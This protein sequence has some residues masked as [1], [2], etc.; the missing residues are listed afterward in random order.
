MLLDV[1]ANTSERYWPVVASLEFLPF[2]EIAV[3]FA[4]LQS[5]FGT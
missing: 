5:D 2:F 3:T 1:A 4:V